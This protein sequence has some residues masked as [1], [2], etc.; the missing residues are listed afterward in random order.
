MRLHILY[1]LL[2]PVALT[3]SCGEGDSDDLGAKLDRAWA[4]KEHNSVIACVCDSSHNGDCE[5]RD[6]PPPDVRQCILA[7]LQTEAQAS[8]KFLDC[9]YDAYAA[10][11]DCM[12]EPMRCGTEDATGTCNDVYNVANAGCVL[13]ASLE[14]GVERCD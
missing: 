3:G 5:N 8:A 4:E 10:F 13:P 1:I 14:A 6:P 9:S 12:A 7:V 2:L 11:A